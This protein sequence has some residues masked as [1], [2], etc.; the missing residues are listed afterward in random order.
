MPDKLALLPAVGLIG[1][2]VRPPVEFVIAFAVCERK[3][4][5]FSVGVLLNKIFLEDNVQLMN[6]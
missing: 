6:T 5:S 2:A 3:S 4:V 1:L